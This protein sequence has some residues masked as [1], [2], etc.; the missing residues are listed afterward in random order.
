MFLEH[1][2]L[3]MP[4]EQSAQVREFFLTT[5]GLCED[6]R[7]KEMNKDHR[8]LWADCGLQQFHLP[9]IP[10]GSIDIAP[11]RLRGEVTLLYRSR[12]ALDKVLYRVGK[13]NACRILEDKESID[14]ENEARI[15]CPFGSIYKLKVT[16]SLNNFIGGDDS[17]PSHPINSHTSL[18]VEDQVIGIESIKLFA[19][20]TSLE[21]IASFWKDIMHSKI[22]RGIISTTTMSLSVLVHLNDSQYI[23]F[24]TRNDEE[25]NNAH[26]YDGHHLCLYLSNYEETYKACEKL[27]ILY[28]PG[29]F[30]DR[31]GSWELAQEHKQF[32]ILHWPKKDSLGYKHLG[33]L[34]SLRIDIDELPSYTLELELR[35]LDH[36]AYP[37]SRH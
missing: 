36:P 14:E 29:R 31:G 10:Q 16:K 33:L 24:V 4:L 32:R 20:S 19:P 23:E 25:E 13:N 3:N 9:L 22:T 21:S 34:Q 15:S 30:A 35:S 2:N 7:P 11:Q 26:E 28:D 1:I 6:I 37:C 8:L 12:K 17:S 18:L 5:L 27:G